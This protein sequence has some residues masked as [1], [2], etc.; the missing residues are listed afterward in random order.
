MVSPSL[1]SMKL[2]GL[3]HRYGNDGPWNPFQ[4]GFGTP[5]QYVRLLIS[6]TATQP[7]VVV[8]Q[9]CNSTLPATC[10]DNRGKLFNKN[11]SSTWTDR[12]LFSLAI[13][14]NL[15]CKATGNFGWDNVVLGLPGSQGGNIVLSDQLVAGIVSQDFFLANWGI[16]PH[17]TNLTD[18]NHRYPS[19]LANLKNSS[20]IPSRSWGYTAG[21]Y[22]RSRV[23]KSA[24]ASLTFGGSDS[25]RYVAHN[26]TFNF[27]VDV[28]RDLVVGVQSITTNATSQNLLGAPIKAFLDA[29]VPH[30]WLPEAACDTF[31]SAFNLTYNSTNGLYFVNDT[32]HSALLE[33]NP[34]ITF[35]LSNDLTSNT[36]AINISF[37]YAAFDLSL[38]SDYPGITTNSTRYFPLR[39]AKN[40][41]QYTLGRTFFQEAYIVADYER[42]SF[43]V[44]QALFPDSQQQ[45]LQSIAPLP[46]TAPITTTPSAPHLSTGV[47]LAISLP[48][49]V[50]FVLILTLVYLTRKRVLA[51]IR[52]WKKSKGTICPTPRAEL[53]QDGR[54]PLCEVSGLSAQPPELLGREEIAELKG[55]SVGPELPGTDLLKELEAG[56]VHELPGSAMTTP[57]DGA[58]TSED[59]I[60]VP[61]TALETRAN[62][63]GVPRKEAVTQGESGI[64][65][66]E[67]WTPSITEDFNSQI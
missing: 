10:P 48:A 26:T 27:A 59:E 60:E 45:S 31:Q 44:H 28:A 32:T 29:G 51:R 2:I 20:R 9:A 30:I 43:S 52:Q 1:S 22:Y 23:S 33:Q 6:T 64:S 47:V 16:R 50:A 14:Q 49:T 55:R 4:I 57:V 24:F 65:E 63:A 41:S 13:E 61:R 8:P 35:T 58:V 19:V 39:Q 67:I 62:E 3:A 11:S 42:S 53:H 18:M 37:P 46:G 36:P 25:N 7:N 21:A 17:E 54:A 12:G 66:G 34:T 56:I 5:P 40:E 38:T 15:G